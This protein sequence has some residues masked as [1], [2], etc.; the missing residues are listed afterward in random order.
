MDGDCDESSFSLAWNAWQIALPN[1]E[2]RHP[3]NQ[4]TQYMM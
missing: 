4:F 2:G 1:A 3:Y